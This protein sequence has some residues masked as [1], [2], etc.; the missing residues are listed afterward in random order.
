MRTLFQLAAT[1]LLITAATT[2]AQI[3]N[4][5]KLVA[6]PPRNPVLPRPQAEAD[7]Q[8]LWQYATPAPIGDKAALEADAR[9]PALLRDN[10]KAPQAM[11]GIGV[12][13][14]DAARIFLAGQGAAVSTD[15][16]HLTL[17]GCVVDHC[18]Q[19]GLLWI[20]LGER[21]PL[22]VF[23]ALRWNEQTRAADEPNAPFT[24]W[25]FPS[26][27]ID[28]HQLPAAL[29]QSLAAFTAACPSSTI[30]STI[31]VDPDGIPHVLGS[32]E[33]GVQPALCN[34]STGPKL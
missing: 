18:A 4:P 27:T 17:T 7:L 11:W 21:N 24:L 9:F 23:A 6:P 31:V 34:P 3:T 1:I 25:L 20:D 33:S 32:L 10:L 29:R 28:P 14:S 15:N 19:R 13:L 8:W 5:D 22:L 16:R 26:R 30:T 12:P 2:Q